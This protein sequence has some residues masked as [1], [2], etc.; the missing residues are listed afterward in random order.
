MVKALSGGSFGV[1]LV[2]AIDVADMVIGELTTRKRSSALQ[3]RL[4]AVS[5]TNDTPGAPIRIHSSNFSG[6]AK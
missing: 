6:Y 1:I 4:S 3:P 5:S 2:A